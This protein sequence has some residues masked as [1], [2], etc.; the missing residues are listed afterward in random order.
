MRDFRRLMVG[1][2]ACFAG[3]WV[4]G[5]SVDQATPKPIGNIRGGTVP[6]GFTFAD[7]QAVG[8]TLSASKTLFGVK[9]TAGVEV[10]SADGK[11]LYQSVLRAGQSLKAQVAVPAKDGALRVTLRTQGVEKNSSVAIANGAAAYTFH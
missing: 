11:L 3:A 9:G 5:C 1:V 7:T 6:A 4:A 2:A 10:S 8:V